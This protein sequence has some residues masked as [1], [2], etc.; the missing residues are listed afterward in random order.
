[1]VLI[2]DWDSLSGSQ[3]KTTPTKWNNNCCTLL[4][5]EPTKIHRKSDILANKQLVTQGDVC[6]TLSDDR[7]FIKNYHHLSRLTYP[8]PYLPWPSSVLLFSP[9]PAQG[10]PSVSVSTPRGPS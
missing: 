1:M 3:F 8:D 7:L 10:A 6:M 5:I 4:E 2:L 9:L